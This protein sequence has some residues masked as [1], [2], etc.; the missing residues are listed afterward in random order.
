MGGLTVSACCTVC[1]LRAYIKGGIE[2]K[3]RL[4][5]TNFLWLAATAAVVLLMTS[6]PAFGQGCALCYTQAAAS[7]SR[8]IHALRDG[9]MIL[10][11]PPTLGS[12]GVA[13]VAYRRRD[14]F[15]QAEAQDSDLSTELND[16]N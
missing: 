14:Q 15:R 16:E 7:G 8:M 11:L 12:V 9:I 2:L 6:L 3:K 1:P 4:N 10:V 13:L 5:H